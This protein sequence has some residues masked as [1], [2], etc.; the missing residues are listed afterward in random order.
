MHS[1]LYW[2]FALT[3]ICAFW[4]LSFVTQASSRSS[5]RVGLLMCAV[6]WLVLL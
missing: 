3:V 4:A 6:C 2:D 5:M 1:D